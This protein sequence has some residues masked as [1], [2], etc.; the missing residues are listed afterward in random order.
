MLGRL[1]TILGRWG[2]RRSLRLNVLTTPYQLARRHRNH[3]SNLQSVQPLLS[4]FPHT[5]KTRQTMS[6]E[7][8]C[9]I[10]H[11]PEQAKNWKRLYSS[12]PERVVRVIRLQRDSPITSEGDNLRD[13]SPAL[14]VL[15][16]I[17]WGR[18]PRE[19]PIQHRKGSL[20]TV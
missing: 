3:P 16:R 20:K 8:Y 13:I 9:F 15:Q 14:A 17:S 5:L 2:T 6:R 12:N 19:P 4:R 11:T 1:N 10:T 18:G 7:D